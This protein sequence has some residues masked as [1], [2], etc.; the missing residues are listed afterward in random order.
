MKKIL[1]MIMV[2]VVLLGCASNSG[3]FRIDNNVYRIATRATW[4]LGGRAGAM[5]M[6]LKSAT[7][8]CKAHGNKVLRVIKSEETY[9]H[10]EGGRVDLTFS[11]EDP[12]EETR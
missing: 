7:Q 5:N 12:G 8:Y 2:V 11:C 10:F 3:V 1:L 6:A 9:G 4:E